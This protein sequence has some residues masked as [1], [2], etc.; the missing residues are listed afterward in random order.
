MFSLASIF[1]VLQSAIGVISSFSGNAQAAK[2]AA[3]VQ[4][5]VSVVTALTPLVQQ[6]AG[7]QDVTEAQVRTALAGK[8]AALAALD[9]EIAKHA[10]P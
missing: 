6:F 3:H 7:G 2:V 5:A 1:P 8:D 10:A 9:A 4:D